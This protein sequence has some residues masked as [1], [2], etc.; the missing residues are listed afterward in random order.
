MQHMAD[1]GFSVIPAIDLMDPTPP[2]FNA[3]TAMALDNVH[4]ELDKYF[5]AQPE[6][7]KQTR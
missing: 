1:R 7:V 3:V 4:R 2:T 6:F 5:E